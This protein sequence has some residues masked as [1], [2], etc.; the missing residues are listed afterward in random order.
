MATIETDRPFHESFERGIGALSHN[1]GGNVNTSLSNLSANR[2]YRIQLKSGTIAQPT[3]QLSFNT[4]VVDEEV[5]V[6]GNLRVAYAAGPISSSTSWTS[7]GWP[8]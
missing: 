2:Y 8:S 6:P 3:V 4:D 7:A 5:N 1:W